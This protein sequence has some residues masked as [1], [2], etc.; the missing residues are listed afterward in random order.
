MRLGQ[1]ARKLEIRT[2]DIVEFLS[3]K[4]IS[5]E[6][7]S[8]TRIEDDHVE[9]IIRHFNPAL[10]I[11]KAEI[12]EPTAEQKM[13]TPSEEVIPTIIESSEEEKPIDEPAIPPVEEI[14]Q[15]EI[16]SE[17]VEVIKAAKAEL[18][19]LKV[20]GKIELPEARKKEVAKPLEE[21]ANDQTESIRPFRR[22]Q[23]Q[24][25]RNNNSKREESWRNPIAQQR[26]LEAREAEKKRKEELEL[27]KEKRTLHYLKK[28]KKIDQPSKNAKLESDQVEEQGIQK[29][30]QPPKTWLG[31][32]LKWLST[33]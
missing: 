5:I 7:G 16:T 12:Q 11:E 9:L 17:P 25:A 26:E 30:E 8:N 31:K 27:D 1:L 15:K 29:I 3:R 4:S 24:P 19:G 21:P 32:F 6:D 20:L 14:N 13:D 28:V 10:L 33:P 23:R 18:P 2:A 22:E